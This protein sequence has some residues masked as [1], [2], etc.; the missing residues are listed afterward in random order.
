MTGGVLLVIRDGKRWGVAADGDMLAVSR[1]KR[2]AE[3]LAREAAEIL[4]ASG[5]KTRVEVPREQRSFKTED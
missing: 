2:G 4:S 3:A 1:T 5:A